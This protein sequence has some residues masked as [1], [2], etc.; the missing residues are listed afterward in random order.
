MSKRRRLGLLVEL[1][2]NVVTVIFFGLSFVVLAYSAFTPGLRDLSFNTLPEAVL[3][4]TASLICLTAF[5]LV[6]VV[7]S[8]LLARRNL[9]RLRDRN[10]VEPK[11]P[12]WEDFM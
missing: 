12:T 8:L 7:G 4:H 3:G 10:Y 5:C 9:R 2:I 11:P 1:V 6:A